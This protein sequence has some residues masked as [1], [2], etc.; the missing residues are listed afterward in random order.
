MRPGWHYP[1]DPDQNDPEPEP[2]PKLT[3][4]DYLSVFLCIG[5][6]IGGVCLYSCEAD[7]QEIVRI[8]P[9]PPPIPPLNREL[10]RTNIVAI[11]NVTFVTNVDLIHPPALIR[12]VATSNLFR[13]KCPNCGTDRLRKA[14]RVEIMGVRTDGEFDIQERLVYF[15][16][17]SVEFKARNEKRIEIPVA[18]EIR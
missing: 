8:S 13:V 15:V 12:Y 7:G 14:K 4:L 6:I 5:A 10:F 18:V 9:Q 16:C 17:C 11:T 3:W 1:G 2:E